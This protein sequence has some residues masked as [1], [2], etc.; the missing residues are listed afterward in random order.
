MVA[1]RL[2]RNLSR[3]QKMSV[4]VES[5]HYV[6]RLLPFVPRVIGNKEQCQQDLSSEKM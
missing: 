1:H 6:Y 3:A 4:P 5:R 2:Y